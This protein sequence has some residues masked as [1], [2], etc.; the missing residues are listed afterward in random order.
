MTAHVVVAGIGNDFRHDDGAGP[1]VARLVAASTPAL[2]IGPIAEPLDLLGR[3]EAAS[4]AVLVDATRS[5]SPPG[6]VKVVDLGS[7]N[8]RSSASTHAVGL[9]RV[10]RLAQV[11]G[12]APDRVVVVGI[13]GED[14]S[15]G[16]GLSPAVARAVGVA[17][18][19]IADLFA[20]AS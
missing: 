17:A 12:T 6:T 15:D 13:E 9:D 20:E 7:T 1:A 11:L 18:A 19:R 3:W 8:R 2:D 16:M 10:V 14:F 5:G 4:F